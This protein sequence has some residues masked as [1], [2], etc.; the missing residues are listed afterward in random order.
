MENTRTKTGTASIEPECTFSQFKGGSRR[1]GTE[2]KQTAN[3]NKTRNAKQIRSFKCNL[4]F[5]FE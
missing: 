4:I 1:F 2:T 5:N 3:N